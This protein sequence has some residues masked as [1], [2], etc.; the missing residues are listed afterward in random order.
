MSM[1]YGGG[2]FEDL[3]TNVQE[4]L[5]P[6]KLVYEKYRKD[7]GDGFT[8]ESVDAEQLIQ[9]MCDS[10]FPSNMEFHFAD[11]ITGG[12]LNEKTATTNDEAISILFEKCEL[13]RN[14]IYHMFW[15]VKTMKFFIY[16]I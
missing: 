15:N 1:V 8:R 11:W 4:D 3:A 10:K 12:D 7:L 6:F 14:K 13:F 16:F 2:S 5:M 9:A